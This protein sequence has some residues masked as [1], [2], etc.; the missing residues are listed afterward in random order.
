MTLGEFIL[1][2][3]AELKLTQRVLSERLGVSFQYVHDLVH[4]NRGSH[5]SDE[6]V[7]KLVKSL[8]IADPVKIYLLCEKHTPKA[9]SMMNLNLEIAVKEYKKFETE[10]TGEVWRRKIVEDNL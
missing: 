5:I 3:M 9:R 2:R 7:S 8:E 6:L 1:Q 10:L 4:D